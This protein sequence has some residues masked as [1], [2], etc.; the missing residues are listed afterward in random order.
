[1]PFCGKTTSSYY[2]VTLNFRT[3]KISVE[4]GSMYSY[5]HAHIL[6]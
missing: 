3:Q 6:E 5:K 4:M 2:K 1:M